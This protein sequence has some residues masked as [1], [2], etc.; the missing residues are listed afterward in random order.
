MTENT[1]KKSRSG[2][3]L[4]KAGLFAGMV[5]IVAMLAVIFVFHER[6]DEEHV[7]V[8][9]RNVIKEPTC[10]EDGLADYYCLGC[11]DHYEEAIPRIGHTIEGE[12]LDDGLIHTGTCAACGEEVQIMQNK[13]TGVRFSAPLKT[14]TKTTAATVVNSKGYTYDYTMYLQ[15]GGYNSYSRYMKH[16]GCSNCALT[17]ILNATCPELKDYTP[18]RVVAEVQ[19]NVFGSKAFWKNYKKDRENGSMPV[20]LYGM[21]KI[22]DEYGVKYKLP[23]ADSSN[24]EK[25]ITDHLTGGDPVIIT[26]ARGG[27]G[28]LSDSVHTVL[29]LGIDADGHVIIGDSLHKKSKNWGKNGL[30]KPGKLTVKDMVSY[31][32]TYEGWSVSEDNYRK[33]RGAIYYKG[34]ADRGYLLIYGEDKTNNSSAE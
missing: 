18:D 14:R 17:S 30:I 31:I 32:K 22:F 13:T 10:S 1:E 29:L 5:A 12:S 3:K 28:G 16:H 6:P 8:Y 24:Y 15:G 34:K 33:D 23:T 7:H 20:T 27:E 9:A 2:K 25:E 4:V 19:Y 26:F 11:N 21:T